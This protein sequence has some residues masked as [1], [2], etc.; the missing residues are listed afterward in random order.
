M[1]LSVAFMQAVSTE[2]TAVHDNQSFQPYSHLPVAGCSL[3]R[4]YSIISPQWQSRIPSL[5]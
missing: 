5:L 4:L 3:S 1:D 2:P